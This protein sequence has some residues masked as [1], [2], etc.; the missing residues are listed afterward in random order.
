MYRAY[1]IVGRT[2]SVNCTLL[3]NDLRSVSCNGTSSWV[4]NHA[5]Y[6]MA[7]EHFRTN[8]LQNLLR[9]QIA[10][11]RG[12]KHGCQAFALVQLHGAN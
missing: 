12:T 4:G 3:N 7:N 2:D 8:P 10:S 11:I 1:A 5:R 6:G 9:Y